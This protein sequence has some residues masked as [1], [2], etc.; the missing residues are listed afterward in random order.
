M[1]DIQDEITKEKYD[2]LAAEYKK[3]YV[4]SVEGNDYAFR[5]FTRPELLMFQAAVE[6]KNQA[7]MEKLAK[8]LC[9]YPELH[10]YEKRIE[11]DGMLFEK[12]FMSFMEL[13]NE[14]KKATVKNF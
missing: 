14:K 5:P 3:V 1:Q 11:E 4:I 8:G 12:T 7:Q 10:E 6:K 2:D 13:Q 9:V